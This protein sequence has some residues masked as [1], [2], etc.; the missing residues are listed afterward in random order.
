MDVLDELAG[1][2]DTNPFSDAKV[3]IAQP[4]FARS[5]AFGNR[6]WGEV[7]ISFFFFPRWEQKQEGSSRS[8]P[9]DDTP[10]QDAMDEIEIDNAES[11]TAKVD[12]VTTHA[13]ECL[14]SRMCRHLTCI[15]T[16][17]P[18]SIRSCTK[19]HSTHTCGH[20]CFTSHTHTNTHTHT[21]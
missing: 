6:D 8:L 4:L 21:Q 10:K 9:N 19:K 18:V 3:C 2:D 15:H 17:L 16:S 12:E 20:A 14:V 11:T 1:V 7:L 5:Y 13:S